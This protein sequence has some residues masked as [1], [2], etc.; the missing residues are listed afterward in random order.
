MHSFSNDSP[1]A[2]IT[3]DTL[4]DT[5]GMGI[6]PTE[7]ESERRVPSGW[8][9]HKASGDGVCKESM[10]PFIFPQQMCSCWKGKGISLSYSAVR[11]LSASIYRSHPPPK[12]SLTVHC[13]LSSKF[14]SPRTTIYYC[15]GS[16]CEGPKNSL[17]LCFWMRHHCALQRALDWE[18]GSCILSTGFDLEPVRQLYELKF[19]LRK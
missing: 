18:S 17:K 4:Y 12:D 19:P 3:I 14:R 7:I 13:L 5:L 16:R 9:S 15:I 2:Y 11:Y 8:W 10:G 6:S 1:N